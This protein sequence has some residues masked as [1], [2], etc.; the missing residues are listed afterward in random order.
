MLETWFPYLTLVSR[1]LHIDHVHVLRR[2]GVNAA[3][4]VAIYVAPSTFRL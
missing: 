2:G 1:P 3:D 4:P